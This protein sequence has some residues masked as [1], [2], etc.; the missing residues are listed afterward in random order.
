MFVLNDL[1][2]CRRSCFDRLLKS[3]DLSMDHEWYQSVYRC[4]PEDACKKKKKRK[5]LPVCVGNM[6][7]KSL[8]IFNPIPS[9][10]KRGG[11]KEEVGV[12]F[13]FEEQG[14]YLPDPSN[15]FCKNFDFAFYRKVAT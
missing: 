2:L 10:G 5:R 7:R 1:I 14:K 3:Y 8:T 4:V 6:S 13:S 12:T 11:R 9:G 15:A